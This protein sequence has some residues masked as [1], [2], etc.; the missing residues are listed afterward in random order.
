MEAFPIKT[1]KSE[2]KNYP[3]LLSEIY[4]PPELLYYRGSLEGAEHYILSVVGTRKPSN[5]GLRITRDLVSA[6]ASRGITIISGLAYGIDA[7]AH[8]AALE[9]GGKTWAVLAS[10]LDSVYPA[11]HRNLAQKILEQGGCLISDYPPGTEPLKQHFPARNRIIAGLSLGTLI[12]EAPD[13][14]GALITANFALE[15]NREVLAVPGEVYNPC[16]VGTNRLIKQGAKV[17]TEAA[18]IL[19]IFGLTDQSGTRPLKPSRPLTD[20]EN[21]IVELLRAGPQTVDQIHEKCTLEI[22]ALNA[23][24]SQLELAEIIYQIEPQTYALNL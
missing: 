10:G 12:A 11:S 4:H 18:D 5:Y 13:K 23:A 2:H 8:V 16:A 6:V 1:I 22:S 17:V 7:Q 19:E 21:V 14:S 24:L 3:A 20:N 15:Y 9:A